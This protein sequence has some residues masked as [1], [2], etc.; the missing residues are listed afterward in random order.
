MLWSTQQLPGPEL[1]R[2]VQSM[3]PDVRRR[4]SGQEPSS[5][6]GD[7]IRTIE[8]AKT[9]A[10]SVPIGEDA[11]SLT[12]VHG[13]AQPGS[14]TETAKVIYNAAD[15]AELIGAYEVVYADELVV[16][17]PVRYAWNI[18]ARNWPAESGRREYCYEA[19][20]RASDGG[21]VFAYEWPN[22]R[23][24]RVIK[25]VR[26]RSFVESNLVTLEKIEVLSKRRH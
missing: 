9:G 1:L 21:T 6:F 3:M 13:A 10:A 16:S 2:D 20:A 15:T 18:L 25:E 5:R 22:P 7:P 23:L 4:L 19:E 14:R 24:G 8:V 17:V 11:T 26:L 12:F